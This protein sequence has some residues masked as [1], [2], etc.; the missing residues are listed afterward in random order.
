MLK[1]SERFRVKSI[2]RIFIHLFIAANIFF[3][4]SY[5]TAEEYPVGLAEIKMPDPK[6]PLN[7]RLWYPATSGDKMALTD[8]N[9]I[10]YGLKVTTSKVADGKFPLI[11]LS[12]G[13]NG[14]RRNQ[15]WLAT[16]LAARGMIVA[17][18]EHPG[19]TSL[20]F[21]SEAT[22]R[23]W[24]RPRDITRLINY[25]L[26]NNNWQHRIDDR[27]IAVVGHSMGG[28]TAL[29]LAGARF[30]HARF[31]RYCQKNPKRA[32]CAWFRENSIALSK[33]S[34]TTLGGDLSD[35]RVKAV[36]SLDLGFTQALTPESL[37]AVK[38]PVLV[39]GAGGGDPEL[40]PVST[41]S[42]LL[43][44][45]LPKKLVIYEE[46]PDAGHFSFLPECKPGAG[47]LLDQ[48]VPGDSVI[49]LDGHKRGRR[50]LHREFQTL[51]GQ[52][53]KSAFSPILINVI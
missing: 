21:K 20:D 22:S 11:I 33:E 38:I 12:H 51:V 36:V 42:R 27:Q 46:I 29:A 7:V 9:A 15:G 4:A 19:T 16:Y 30:D 49:C 24:E 31:D 23:L 6:R 32:D 18:L 35:A 48:E 28:Y 44:A 47:V 17:S 14:N 3:T 50:E 1:G 43:A 40:L 41:E 13:L 26:A 8:D 5:L 25:L 2:F 37:A 45:L 53:L 39:I 10:F 52:F 34:K